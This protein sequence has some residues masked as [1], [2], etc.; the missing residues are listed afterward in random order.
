MLPQ[1]ISVLQ[2]RAEP[3]GITVDVRPVA[4]FDF[5]ADTVF[6]MLLQYP[7]A[8]GQIGDYRELVIKAKAANVFT[9][10]AADLLALTLLT[11][12]GEWGERMP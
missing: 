7:G 6:G 2:T 12:P 10:A 9:V 5:P 4:N 8:D 1:T 11:P 3:L